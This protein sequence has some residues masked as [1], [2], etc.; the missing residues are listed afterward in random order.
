[1]SQK[2]TELNVLGSPLSTD[3]L[4]VV[5]D[6]SGTKL[7]RAVTIQNVVASIN[8]DAAGFI[9]KTTVQTITGLKT[10]QAASNSSVALT[11]KGVASQSENLVEMKNSTPVNKMTISQNG[12]IRFPTITFNSAEVV[13]MEWFCPGAWGLRLSVDTG[14]GES[15]FYNTTSGAVEMF[16]VGPTISLSPQSLVIKP[17]ISNVGQTVEWGAT[18]I[19]LIPIE[20]RRFTGTIVESWQLK[21]YNLVGGQQSR[22]RLTQGDNTGGVGTSAEAIYENCLL[23]STGDGI[24]FRGSIWGDGISSTSA[25]RKR[26]D[27]TPSF[28]VSTDASFTTRTVFSGYDFNTI[29]SGREAMRFDTTGSAIRVGF[30]GAVDSNYEVM[31]NGSIKVSGSINV[32]GTISSPPIS[33]AQITSD[34]NNYNPGTAR[35]LRLNS[36]ASRNITGLVAGIDGQEVNIINV[37]SNNIVLVHQSASSTTTNRF[38]NTTGTDITLTA[39]QAA[40]LI[41]DATDS[42]WR[43]F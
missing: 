2:L 5:T 24:F 38:L 28:I 21:T 20:C 31:V 6:P 8:K 11:I 30:L 36:D 19:S 29:T 10:F 43:V 15:V 40:S 14:T 9:D 26:F 33:P 39:N 13:G 23:R 27:I 16:R 18:T 4:Y 17:N 7:S 34:Q 32:T 3:Y 41:Y 37:G 35:F 25:A 42:R 22:F 12:L 1:M